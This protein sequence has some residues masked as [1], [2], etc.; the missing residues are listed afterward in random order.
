MENLFSK[1]NKEKFTDNLLREISKLPFG[2]LP[3]A[4]LEL[5]ILHSIIEAYGGYDEL[6][7]NSLFIQRELMLSQTK[8]K[9]KVL[10]AQL[11]FDTSRTEPVEFFNEIIFQKEFSDLIFEENYLIIYL[12]NPFKRDTLKTYLDSIEVLNDASFNNGVIKIHSKG[13][14]KILPKI[15]D[16]EDLLTKIETQI[17][18]ACKLT[19]NNSFSLVG[20]INLESVFSA[21]LSMDPLKSAK[22][23]L[24]TIRG[25]FG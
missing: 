10:E 1:L 17:I 14:L 12:S 16:E 23:L 5:A 11:R 18:D 8:F 19:T 9:N 24:S 3:K 25:V 20:S 2:S 21:N 13:L 6:N 15:I 4:E 7:K 22:K